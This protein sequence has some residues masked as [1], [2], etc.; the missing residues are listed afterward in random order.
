SPFGFDHSVTKGI[1]SAK[2]RTLPNDTY[3]PFIQ[4]DVSTLRLDPKD[5]RRVL[6]RV[7]LS[8]DTPVKED[9]QAKLT[10]AGVTG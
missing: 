7:R 6:A 9:T 5:P 2:G 3:V 8:A 10:L 1:V 4:T